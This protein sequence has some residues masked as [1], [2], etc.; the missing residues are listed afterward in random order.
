[1]H[2]QELTSAFS[3]EGQLTD[4][5][6]SERRRQIQAEREKLA[7]AMKVFRDMLDQMGYFLDFDEKGM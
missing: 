1:V 5:E 2:K 6:L 4:V 7:A 3:V